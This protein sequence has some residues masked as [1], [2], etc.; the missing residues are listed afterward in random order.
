MKVPKPMLRAGNH[1]LRGSVMSEMTFAKQP[2]SRTLGSIHVSE[3]ETVPQWKEFTAKAEAAKKAN[4][5]H[6]RAK[7]SMR[8]AF[9]EA[10]KQPAD[11]EIEFSKT[12]D[13]VTVIEVLEKKQP[14]RA[15]ASD[16]SGLFA[17]TAR[18]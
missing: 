6:E 15:R 4:E 2:K 5:A 7:Q 11:A 16:M 10:L 17:K 12:G 9:R 8:E 14:K 3:L 1:A 18:K 13:R